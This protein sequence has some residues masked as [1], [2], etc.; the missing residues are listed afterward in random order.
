MRMAN[1]RTGDPALIKLLEARGFTVNR[2]MNGITY[3]PSQFEEVDAIVRE[4]YARRRS[5]GA[6][7]RENSVTIRTESDLLSAL[8]R[9]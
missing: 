8:I 4:F 1:C 3:D 5:V 7:R 9:G 6:N 2:S